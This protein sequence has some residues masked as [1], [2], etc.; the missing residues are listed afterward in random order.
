VSDL[1]LWK[2]MP[3]LLAIPVQNYGQHWYLD[4]ARVP[5][6]PHIVTS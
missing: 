1:V 6:R 3:P 4:T 2:H 5:H